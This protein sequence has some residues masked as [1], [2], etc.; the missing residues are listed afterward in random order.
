MME[1]IETYKCP[2]CQTV[3]KRDITVCTSCKEQ[4]TIA[5]LKSLGKGSVP[6]GYVWPI[7][8]YSMS[9]GSSTS[10]D[11]VIPSN[12]LA[13]KH[14]IFTYQKDAMFIE[15]T[16]KENPVFMNG[17]NVQIG[18]MQKLNEGSTIRLGLDEFKIYYHNLDQKNAHLGT[19]ADRVQRKLDKKHATN[20]IAARLML[21]LGYLQEL[22]SSMD[23]KDLL[24]NS[25]DAVLKLTNLDRGYAFVTEYNDGEMS[26]KEVV[27]RK[28][29]GLDFFEKD[30]TISRSM[31]N[32]VLQG[33]GTVI[34]EDADDNIQTT[35]SMRDF[36]IKSI[37]C[38]PLKSVD[39]ETQETTLLG[40]IYADKMMMT[41]PL[42]KQIRTTLQVLSQLIVANLGRCQKYHNALG[43]CKQYNNYIENLANEISTINGNMGIIA[44][45][46]NNSTDLENFKSMNQYIGGE[47]EKLNAIIQSLVEASE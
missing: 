9:I 7:Y 28:L 8:P 2:L 31:L 13:K 1:K 3:N 22:H 34:I 24:G 36:Q 29:G 41:T 16:D 32:K 4:T 27:S 20:P 45:N 19:E 35:N 25:V 37:V 43:T 6:E 47:K 46:M 39:P 42:P 40:V 30:Y 10:N 44:E 18:I 38:L 26:L 17:H 14:C 15:R 33:D 12:R 11:I 5:V 21:M 23:I